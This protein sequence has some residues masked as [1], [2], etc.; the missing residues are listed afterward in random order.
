M[1]SV[2]FVQR[3]Q[4]CR[5]HGEDHKQGS[6]GVSQ[7]LFREKE[8]RDT[9]KQSRT[10]AYQLPLGQIKKNF[11]FDFG[12]VFGDGYIGHFLPP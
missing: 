3:Q 11:A 7:R 9:H 8:Q 1:L 10:E 12:K 5:E 4:K 2:L 6:G